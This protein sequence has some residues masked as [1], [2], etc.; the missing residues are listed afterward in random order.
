MENIYENENPKVD[1]I[2]Y[3]MEKCAGSNFRII[4]YNYFINNNIYSKNEIFIPQNY[5]NINFNKGELEQV[6]EIVK[7]PIYKNLKVILS[8]TYY[9]DIGF[10]YL[11]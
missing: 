3:H 10:L 9:Y 4:L 1:F 5:N 8:Y 7:Q 6:K 2:F 11:V